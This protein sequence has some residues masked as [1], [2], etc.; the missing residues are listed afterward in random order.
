MVVPVGFTVSLDRAR[1]A[2]A[3]SVVAFLRAV[4]GSSENDLLAGS[5]CH[6]WSRL[7]VAVHVLAGWQEM[8]GGFVSPVDAEPTVDAA[9]YWPA[10]AQANATDDPVPSLMWQRRR[11]VTYARPA[12]ALEHLRDVAAALL[13]GV[14]A[15][16]E[17]HY[18]WQ[19]QVFA[20]GDFLAIWAVED[21]VHH[22]DLESEEPA[23]ASALALTRGTIEALI[24]TPSPSAWSDVD[25]ALIGTGRVPVPAD[26]GAIAARLPALG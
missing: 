15:C 1:E 4:E 26:G 2:C 5:R 20:A 14:A 7:D 16:R 12:A 17:G 13:R 23:P 18:L 9:S 25:A 8:L 22:L 11:T 10:F 21:V 24:G 6:G 3:E 19:D